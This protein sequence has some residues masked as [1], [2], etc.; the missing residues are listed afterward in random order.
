MRIAL[1]ATG[2]MNMGGAILFMPI[3][4]RLREFNGL[5]NAAHPLYLWI[6]SIW[7]FLFGVGYLWL[8]L[9]GKRERL[10]LLI[11]A[12]GKLSFFGLLVVY[13]ANGELPAQAAIGG[14]ADLF[15]GLIFLYWLWQTRRGENL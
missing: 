4:P 5:P 1:L 6:I 15:F 14:L 3:F 9:T 2:L 8:G 10:F 11:G 12:G 7:I 13:W